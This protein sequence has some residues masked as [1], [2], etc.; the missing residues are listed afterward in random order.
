M[1]FRIKLILNTNKQTQKQFL[2]RV[3]P[4]PSFC[5]AHVYTS[6]LSVFYLSVIVFIS[7]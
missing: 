6:V 7:L 4:Q 3:L 5:C 1:G 2:G